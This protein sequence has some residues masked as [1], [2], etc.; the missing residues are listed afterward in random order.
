MVKVGGHNAACGI[1]IKASGLKS[2]IKSVN[3]AILDLPIVEVTEE[4]N[5]QIVVDNY[6]SI[7][8]INKDTC[9]ALKNLYFFTETNPVFALTDITI[10]NVKYSGKNANNICYT[11]TDSTG[12]IST[13]DWGTGDLYKQLGCPKNVTLIAELELKFGKPALNILNIIPKG[14]V[15]YE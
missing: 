13:W 4:V 6:I 1:T 11:I 3:E 7:A 14:E 12:T 9:E 5:P 2:F 8:D 10:T 15:I